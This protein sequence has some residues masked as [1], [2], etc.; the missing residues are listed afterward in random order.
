MIMI[1]KYLSSIKLNSSNVICKISQRSHHG[2]SIIPDKN[3]HLSTIQKGH[4]HQPDMHI[5][6]TKRCLKRPENFGNLSLFGRANQ[7]SSLSQKSFSKIQLYCLC[8]KVWLCLYQRRLGKCL[9]QSSWE[10]H[11]RH[12]IASE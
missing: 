2:C 6:D 3:S 1:F 10:A 12:G 5:F 11:L 9:S 8:L 4:T 7:H